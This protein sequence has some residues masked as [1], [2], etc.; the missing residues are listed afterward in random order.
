MA[1]NIS[2]KSP[3]PQI[4][5]NVGLGGVQGPY[6][7]LELERYTSKTGTNSYAVY[8][9]VKCY[10]E[11]RHLLITSKLIIVGTVTWRFPG[12]G[13]GSFLYAEEG[14]LR[15]IMN[16][17]GLAACEHRSQYMER[18]VHCQHI[19]QAS[20]RKMQRSRK[21]TSAQRPSQPIWSD[22]LI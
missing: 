12:E 10:F 6:H 16:T 14:R 19:W 8:A 2:P 5:L 20:T 21:N 7:K 15:K 4:P 3:A 17:I 11:L 13:A 1:P 22:P 18:G 9:L